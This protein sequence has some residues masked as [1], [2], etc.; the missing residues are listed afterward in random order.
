MFKVN[1][2]QVKD[3]TAH[4]WAPATAAPVTATQL[5]QLTSKM[6]PAMEVEPCPWDLGPGKLFPGPQKYSLYEFTVKI[7]SWAPND[8]WGPNRERRWSRRSPS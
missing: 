6:Q 7:I 5:A 4:G 3:F 8:S 2:L 1:F